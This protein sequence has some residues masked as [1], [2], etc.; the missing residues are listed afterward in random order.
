MSQP[1]TSAVVSFGPGSAS[2]QLELSRPAGVVLLFR[3]TVPHGAHVVADGWLKRL[4][5]VRAWS[6]PRKNDPALSCARHGAFD[7]CT[8]GEESCPVPAA[9][10]RFRL[11]KLAGPAGVTRLDFVVG[12]PSDPD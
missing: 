11:R 2:R 1:R 7:V 9:D 10:W 5:G 12:R 3:L 6:W 4:A 8:Q